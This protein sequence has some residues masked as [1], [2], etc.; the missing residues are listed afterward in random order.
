MNEVVPGLWIGDWVAARDHAS[1]FDTV[2][3]V[4]C[5]APNSGGPQFMLVDGP[6]NSIG[7]YNRADAGRR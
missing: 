1:E 2:V 4:A 6:G 3:N 5:D 7:E